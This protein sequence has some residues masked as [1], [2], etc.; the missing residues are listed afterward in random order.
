VFGNQNDERKKYLLQIKEVQDKLTYAMDLLTS[1]LIEP[2]DFR[3]MKS[4]YN[5]R[6][7][8]LHAKLASCGNEHCNLKE[9]LDKGLNTLLGLN[10]IY[11]K[12]GNENKQLVISTMFPGKLYFENKILRTGTINSIAELIYQ[13]N[14]ELRLEGNKNTDESSYETKDIENIS[15]RTDKTKEKMLHVYS[16]NDDFSANKKGRNRIKSISSCKVGVAGFEPTTS[17]S[18]MWRDT[19]LRYTPNWYL[20][21]SLNCYGTQRYKKTYRCKLFK[22]TLTL[23]YPC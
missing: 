19:G 14:N 6:L 11:E 12:E 5:N 4:D 23:N 8:R 2:A 9:L 20:S 22:P 7:E 17:T 1:R 16:L 18:Q 3:D 15:L 13:I 10:Y 21:H